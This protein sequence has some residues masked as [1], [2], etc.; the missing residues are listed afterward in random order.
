MHFTSLYEKKLEFVQR[1]THN[2]FVFTTYSNRS[3]FVSFESKNE[4]IKVMQINV[5]KIKIEINGKTEKS[6]QFLIPSNYLNKC[7]QMYA[8]E[9][10]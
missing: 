3:L 8:C 9:L 5:M 1:K 4:K 10:I 2:L 7:F 6:K